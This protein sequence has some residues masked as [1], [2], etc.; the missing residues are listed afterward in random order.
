MEYIKADDMISPKYIR[1]SK[2]GSLKGQATHSFM[3]MAP[4]YAKTC[5]NALSK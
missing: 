2:I 4:P 1:K 3:C 5:R